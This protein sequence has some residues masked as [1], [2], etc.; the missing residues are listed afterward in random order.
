M[1]T[2]DRGKMVTARWLYARSATWLPE[3]LARQ[4][5]AV[6]TICQR[7]VTRPAHSVIDDTGYMVG[8]ILLVAQ[9]MTEN[10][11]CRHLGKIEVN[12]LHAIVH[13]PAQHPAD[14]EVM[15]CILFQRCQC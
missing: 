6:I 7:T 2:S 8:Q 10:A 3:R 11:Q 13:G 9:T 1:F 14:P 15:A 4:T 5:V 12:A